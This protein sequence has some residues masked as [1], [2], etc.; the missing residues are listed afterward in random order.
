MKKLK[1]LIVIV[2]LIIIAVILLRKVGEKLYIKYL[3]MTYPEKYNSYVVEYSEKYDLD[4]MFV[5]GIIKT[6]SNLNPNALSNVGAKGLMQITNQTGQDIAEKLGIQNFQPDMLYDPQIN[7]EFG[8]YYLSKLVN[9]FNNDPK[10]V[11]AAYNAGAG[12]VQSWLNNR[13]YS[14]DGIHLNYIPFS[15]T[16]E[17]VNK[18]I[19]NEDMY[20]RL[21]GN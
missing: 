3:Y 2:V 1:R 15:E 17:Y 20:K 19:K 16:R 21:Y 6:E 18:V 4:P 12:N 8:T 14:K 9:E 10:L 11:I 5:R 7:I 13:E